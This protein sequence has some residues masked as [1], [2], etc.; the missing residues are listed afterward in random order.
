MRAPQK[1]CWRSTLSRLRGKESL[2]HSAVADAET[3][4]ADAVILADLRLLAHTA[5]R[6]PDLRRHLSVQAAAANPDAINF[7][8]D[9]FDVRRVAARAECRGNRRHQPRD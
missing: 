9:A 5:E 7:Y 4:G 6:H 1:Y 8:A 2:W 3:A